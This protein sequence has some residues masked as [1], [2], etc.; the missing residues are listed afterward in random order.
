MISDK[1]TDVGEKIGKLFCPF[2]METGRILKK[3][4]PFLDKLACRETGRIGDIKIEGEK[5]SENAT[6]FPF[7]VFY[8]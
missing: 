7:R 8:N 2:K 5:I 1:W 3:S 4:G 6:F